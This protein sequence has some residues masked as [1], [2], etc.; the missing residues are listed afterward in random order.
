MILWPSVN[1]ARL[2]RCSPAWTETQ[3]VQVESWPTAGRPVSCVD[4]SVLRC[5]RCHLSFTSQLIHHRKSLPQA[6]ASHSSFPNAS[7]APTPHA[8][9]IATTA[10]AIATPPK[11]VNGTHHAIT[12]THILSTSDPVTPKLLH[13]AEH[14]PNSPYEPRASLTAPL[15]PSRAIPRSCAAAAGAG[16]SCVKLATRQSLWSILG[17]TA[18]ARTDHSPGSGTVTG[19][20]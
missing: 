6:N 7:Q 1:P 2:A 8:S 15:L 17:C 3:A 5:H 11:P 12:T 9:A 18:T 14:R 4:S 20:S 16:G 13:C 19:L 10:P